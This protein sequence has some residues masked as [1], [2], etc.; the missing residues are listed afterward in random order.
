MSYNSRLN[1]VRDH[2][3]RIR[4]IV[5]EM[6]F[7]DKDGGEKSNFPVECPSLKMSSVTP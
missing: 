2:K 7:V 1:K 6:V 4:D 5:K 3:I